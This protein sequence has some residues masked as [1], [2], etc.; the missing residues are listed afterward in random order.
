MIKM[1]DAF[2]VNTGEDG[3]LD[4]IKVGDAIGIKEFEVATHS[5]IL[6]MGKYKEEIKEALDEYI[7]LLHNRLGLKQR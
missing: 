4:V 5:A 6:S 3:W 2:R 1:E 7:Q